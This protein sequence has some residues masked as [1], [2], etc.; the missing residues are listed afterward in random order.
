[1]SDVKITGLN[2]GVQATT[3]D[4]TELLELVQGGVNKFGLVSQI[5]ALVIDSAP[6]LLNTLDELAAALG[7][8]ANFAATIATSLAG[9]LNLT[10]G[11]VSGAITLSGL[12]ASRALILDSEKSINVSS[13]TD[14]EL[15]YMGGVTSAIQTQ[16]NSLVTSVS[17]RVLKAGD[18]MTGLLTVAQATANTAVFASTGYSLTGSNATSLIDLVGTWNTSGNPTA[19]KINI[20][21]TASGL[22]SLLADFQIGGV[23]QGSLTKGGVLNN[24][25]GISLASNATLTWVGRGGIAPSADGVFQF[26]TNGFSTNANLAVEATNTLAL[27]NSTTAQT[28]N[29][30]GTYTDA[31]NYERLTIAVSTS[32]ASI[33]TVKAG[34]GT[35]RQLYLAGSSASASLTLGGTAGAWNI[36]SSGHFLAGTDNIYDIGASGATRPR[37]VFA[38][39][40]VVT[41]STVVAS[42]PSASTAGSGARAFVTD[43]STTV[44]LGLG[45]TVAGGGAN[46]V[47]VYSDGTNWIVG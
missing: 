29:I 47:P 43:A 23:S 36:N 28:F 41:L 22:S 5:T 17:S 27:R 35:Q 25:G 12:T 4:G 44:I 16:F 11:T 24:T 31:S 13:V 15:S 8:D 45:A 20:T 9:K 39:G 10:G 18:T 14:T 3:L 38:S 34:T 21:N 19:L 6:A 30:Y 37:N 46:K 40:Y 2:G 7:D 33:S 1:M 32:S 42:L 26:F